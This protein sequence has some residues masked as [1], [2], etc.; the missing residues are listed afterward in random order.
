MSFHRKVRVRRKPISEIN[1]VPYIDVMLVLLLIFM[2]TAP[3]LT[4]GVHVQLPSASAKPM[5]PEKAP[6]IIVSV[7]QQGILF[8][9]TSITPTQP[10]SPQDLMSQVSSQLTNAQTEHKQLDVYVKGDRNASY[11]FVMKAMVLLQKAG[12][13]DVG[14]ITKSPMTEDAANGAE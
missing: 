10:I 4:Q 6:P 13:N 12:A 5:P 7:N 3:L 8:L 1:L 9:S 14:L 2:M 11:G